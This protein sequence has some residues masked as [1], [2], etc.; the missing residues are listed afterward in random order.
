MSFAGGGGI[1]PTLPPNL[2]KFGGWPVFFF[3]FLYCAEPPGSKLAHYHHPQYFKVK[4]RNYNNKISNIIITKNNNEKRKEK[5]ME[6][7]NAKKFPSSLALLTHMHIFSQSWCFAGSFWDDFSAI[8]WV[9]KWKVHW[10]Y[11]W[12]TKYPTKMPFH[13]GKVRNWVPSPVLLI[14]IVFL[15]FQNECEISWTEYT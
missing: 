12:L 13:A 15:F 7:R 2:A 1:S 9:I 5:K 3:L 6:C 11:W 14:Y 8:P 4:C 10:I